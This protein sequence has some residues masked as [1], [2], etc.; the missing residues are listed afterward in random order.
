NVTT[1]DVRRH[2]QAFRSTT[3]FLGNYQVLGYVNQTTGQVTGVRGLQ[4][5]ICQTLT[6]TVG[7][8]EVLEYV[9][10]FTEVRSDRRFDDGAIRLG[11]QAPHTGQLTNLC[12]GTPGTGISHHVNRVERLLH[13]VFAVFALHRLAIGANNLLFGQTFHHRLGHFVVSAGPDVDNLVVL[14]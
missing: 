12:R 10:A 14:L 3:V 13:Q 2:Q 8:D 5:R 4:C 6:S 11:H 7:G 9:Q 1:F